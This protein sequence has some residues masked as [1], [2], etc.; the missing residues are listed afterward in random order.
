MS[1]EHWKLVHDYKK[2]HLEDLNFSF[3]FS[4][5][6]Q[7]NVQSQAHFSNKDILARYM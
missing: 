4:S 3:N 5:T 2:Q 1:C 7:L 6:V